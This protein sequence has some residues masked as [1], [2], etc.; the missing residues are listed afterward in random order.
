MKKTRPEEEVF[1]SLEDLCTSPGFVHAIAYICFRDNIIKYSGELKS[2]D[3]AEMTSHDKLIRTEISTLIGLMLKKDIDF[4]IPKPEIIQNYIATTDNLMQELHDTITAPAQEIFLDIIENKKDENPFTRGK[5][6][7]ESIFYSGDSAYDFQYLELTVEKYINDDEWFLKNKVFSVID[8]KVIIEA[9]SE[10]QYEKLSSF[11]D[12]LWKT[13]PSEWTLLGNYIFTIEDLENKTH[14]NKKI[15]KNVLDSFVS[16]G[17]KNDSFSHLGD[18]NIT[19]AK[20]LIALNENKYISF[21]HYSILEAFYESP[22]YWFMEDKPYRKVAE[23]NR[24]DFT[25]DFSY[26]TLCKVFGEDTT[27]REMHI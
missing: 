10:I 6:L 3:I 16:V 24:G 15:I 7:R 20:P 19:N 9:I 21:Q 25:E 1:Q 22:F 27:L 14:I 23:K 5:F 8:V 18:F 17:E 11:C 2:E 12:I 26:K 4:S 13:H